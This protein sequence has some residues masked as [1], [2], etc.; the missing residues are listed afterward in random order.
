MSPRSSSSSLYCA[1][2]AE[3]VSLWDTAAGEDSSDQWSFAVDSDNGHR[4]LPIL[5]SEEKEHMPRMDYRSRFF[6]R[7]LHATTRQDSINW[8]FKVIDFYQFRPV[9]AYLSVNYLDRFLSTNNLP[10]VTKGN[11]AHRRINDGWPMQLLSVACLSIA[12]KLEETHVPLLLDLQIL[13]PKYV[14]DPKTVRRMELFVMAAL[15]WR[16][17]AVTPFDF[18]LH[19]GT[20]IFPQVDGESRPFLFSRAADLIIRTHRVVDFL[21]FRP[22]IISAA[23]LLCAASDLSDPSSNDAADCLGRLYEYVNQ[24]EVGSCL[25]LMEEYLIDTC[26]SARR[27]KT[28]PLIEPLT[29]QSPVGVLDAA[30]CASCHTRKSS[31]GVACN[32]DQPQM[33]RRRLDERQCTDGNSW[34]R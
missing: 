5:L 8:I 30:S 2:D 18:F 9:T 12:A 28:K 34:R 19:F 13:D 26:P 32:S 33:K 10:S 21:G 16:M 20:T 4:P 29:P 11:D 22:S 24:D 14:F 17:R 7:T 31:V 25:Q 15:R 3:D 6:S 27:F 23:A 1:E